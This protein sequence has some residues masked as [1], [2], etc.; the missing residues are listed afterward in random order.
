MTGTSCGALV[1]KCFC[2]GRKSN[3]EILHRQ[4]N[5]LLVCRR[6]LITMGANYS[7]SKIIYCLYVYKMSG[8]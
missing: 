3:T 5:L 7:I 1:L 6:S 2:W 8:C 4:E